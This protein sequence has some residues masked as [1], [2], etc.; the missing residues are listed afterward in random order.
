MAELALN[1]DRVITE[2]NKKRQTEKKKKKTIKEK[3]GY[4]K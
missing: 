3:K 2:Q 4:F 1:E